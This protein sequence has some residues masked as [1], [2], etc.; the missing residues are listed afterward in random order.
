MASRILVR[1]TLVCHFNYRLMT[2]VLFF[3]GSSW[4][5]TG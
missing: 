3:T 1:A 2:F 5:L 4:F